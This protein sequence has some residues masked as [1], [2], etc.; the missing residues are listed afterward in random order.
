M[1]ALNFTPEIKAAARMSAF[2]ENSGQCTALRHLVVPPTAKE[3]LIDV[4][5]ADSETSQSALESLEHSEFAKIIETSPFQL[6]EGYEKLSN[7]K[8]AYKVGEKFPEEIEEHW[9]EVSTTPIYC[10]LTMF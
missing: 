9:R 4:F 7:F 1:V 8:V 2:I 10:L 6:R 5:K 3:E